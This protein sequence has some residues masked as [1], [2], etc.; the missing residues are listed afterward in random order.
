MP[1]IGG[2]LRYVKTVTMNENA[3]I[4]SVKKIFRNSFKASYVSKTHLK[5][6]DS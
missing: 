1:R 4:S 5:F 3:H 2:H 6:E